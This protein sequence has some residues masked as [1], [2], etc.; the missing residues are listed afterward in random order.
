[1]PTL[2]SLIPRGDGW[3][4]EAS[5]TSTSRSA[6]VRSIRQER[7][8]EGG[9][10]RIGEEHGRDEVPD[11]LRNVRCSISPQEA[12]DNRAT[13]VAAEL[14]KLVLGVVWQ[15]DVGPETRPEPTRS[16]NS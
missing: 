2:W 13:S 11:R 7:V 10:R 16:A 4:G 12:L 1:M 14:V 15:V 8:L 5:L 6:C 9:V 3:S